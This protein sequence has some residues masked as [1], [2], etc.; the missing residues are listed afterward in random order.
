MQDGSAI[1]KSTSEYGSPAGVT[2]TIEGPSLQRREKY[3]SVEAFQA[4]HPKIHKTFEAATGKARAATLGAV[5]EV[6]GAD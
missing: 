5:V 3:E 2:T 1:T 6:D 4:A